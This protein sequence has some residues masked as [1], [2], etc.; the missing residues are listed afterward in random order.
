ML[1][2]VSG[3]SHCIGLYS[4]SICAKPWRLYDVDLFF[5]Q[6]WTSTKATCPVLLIFSPCLFIFAFFC[7]VFSFDLWLLYDFMSLAIVPYFHLFIFLHLFFF[8][9]A[10]VGCLAEN[11]C[12]EK[13]PRSSEGEWM[14]VSLSIWD[15]PWLGNLI[16]I[17]GTD[18]GISFA[19]N[20]YCWQRSGNAF[21]LFNSTSL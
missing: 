16:C 18:R 1:L 5:E 20:N 21:R 15:V 10:E 14:I 3:S 19:S 11:I 12:G 17:H 7:S 6:N 9:D 4:V 2:P 8:G 13:N